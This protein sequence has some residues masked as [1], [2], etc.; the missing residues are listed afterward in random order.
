MQAAVIG[1]WKGCSPNHIWRRFFLLCYLFRNVSH[2]SWRKFCN[3]G[4]NSCSYLK[5]CWLLVFLF[6]HGRHHMKCIHAVCFILVYQTIFLYSNRNGDKQKKSNTN[7]QCN[8][9]NLM[10]PELIN[11]LSNFHLYVLISCRSTDDNLHVAH[12]VFT[13][14]C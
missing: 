7:P 4:F 5:I 3:M 12:P 8:W 1:T 11:A 9:K 14:K 13:R 10:G 6:L 2:G